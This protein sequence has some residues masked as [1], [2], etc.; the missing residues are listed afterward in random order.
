MDEIP[1]YL[2]KPQDNNELPSF[3]KKYDVVNLYGTNKSSGKM[4]DLLS[5][6][7]AN[8]SRTRTYLNNL[9]NQN[10]ERINKYKK[11]P[12]TLPSAWKDNIDY[13]KGYSSEIEDK[14]RSEHD[15]LGLADYLSKFKMNNIM[16]QRAYEQE[17][18][19]LRRYG[20]QYNAIQANATDEQRESIAFLEAFNS[21]NI[22]DLDNDNDYKKR[23][24][25][26]ISILGKSL[27][28]T[29]VSHSGNSYAF[30]SDYPGGKE[31]STITVTFNTKHVSEA[32]WGCGPDWLAKDTDENQYELFSKD[33]GYSPSEIRNILGDNSISTKEG[34][35]IVTVPK[36]NIEGIKFLTT[37]SNWYNDTGRTK[38]DVSYASYDTEGNLLDDH[39]L[40]IDNKL[41]RISDIIKK[42]NNDKNVI[43]NSIG[44][45]EQIMSTTI[46]PYMNEKQMQLMNMRNRG[47]M[48][49]NKVEEEIKLDN[50]IYENLLLGL[51]FSK[52]DIYTDKNNEIEG[53][54][55]LNP[56]TNNLEKGKLK[57]YV[58]NAIRDNR[59][60]FNAGISGGKYGTYLKIAPKDE[61]GNI[62]TDNDDSRKGSV[63]FIPGLFTKSV[64]KAFDSSTQGKTVAEINSMQQYGY[65]YTLSNG[66]VLSN[67][68]N[69]TARLYDA[70]TDTYRNISREEAHDL[71]HES[72]IIED[73]TTNIRNRM[74]NLDGTLRQGYNYEDDIKKITLAAANELYDGQSL[75]SDDLWTTSKEKQKENEARGDI[76]YDYKRNRALDIYEQL[77]NSIYKL[78]NFNK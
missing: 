35:I 33:T 52:Y 17:I 62:I 47:I 8:N 24:I 56:L 5:E 75:T 67:V 46:L 39:T 2:Q 13:T 12:K 71:L 31:S 21:G 34:K 22:D 53:D 50:K 70:N 77:R 16:D 48:D 61:D 57:D 27:A 63:I 49:A 23:Y 28:L 40:E 43:E 74:F 72:I 44:A 25:E 37:V 59:V 76:Y 58:R 60:T 30:S 11:V 42:V 51:S 9:Y 10:M 19:Q 14:F 7:L 38:N 4:S 45:G 55:T 69:D 29:E 6:E 54:E 26:A 15:Y 65:E 20:R 78:L 36:S 3:L 66:N 41:Q 18:S 68:G 64:Q 73:A 32:F 1:F